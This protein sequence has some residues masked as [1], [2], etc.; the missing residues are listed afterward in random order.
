MSPETLHG[1]RNIL[2][3]GT[4]ILVTVESKYNFTAYTS[5]EI[6]IKAYISLFLYCV[7]R[8]SITDLQGWRIQSLSL[9]ETP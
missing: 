4:K 5:V 3:V 7:L 1:Y 6:K 2:P 9:Y 8:K